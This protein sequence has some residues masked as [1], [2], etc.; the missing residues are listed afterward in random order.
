M[1]AE[2]ASLVALDLNPATPTFNEDIV[3]TRFLA[4]CSGQGIADTL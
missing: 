1:L 2:I 4:V 3:W